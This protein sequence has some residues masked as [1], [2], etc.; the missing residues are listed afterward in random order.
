MLINL[1]KAIFNKKILINFLLF[2]GVM[3]YP[4]AIFTDSNINLESKHN[5]MVMFPGYY[6][7]KV[8]PIKMKNKNPV[9]GSGR[10]SIIN[11]YGQRR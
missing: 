7:H 11:F 2:S 5:R 9:L 6:S 4:L 3:F 10:Y 1:Y 8:Y